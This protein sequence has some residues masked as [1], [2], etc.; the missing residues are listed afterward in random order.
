[1]TRPALTR[2]CLVVVF[3]A[4]MAWVEAASVYYLRAMVDRIEPY[5]VNP[6]P[7]HGVLGPVEVV[8]EAAT[9]VMLLMVGMLTARTWPRR[10]GYTAIA[11]GVWDILYYGFLKIICGW[12]TSIFDWDILFLLPLPWWGPVIAPVSIALL[13]VAWGTLATQFTDGPSGPRTAR[14]RRP[15]LGLG[16]VGIALALAVFMVDSLRTVNQGRDV[17]EMLPGPFNWPAFCV[18][19]ACMA[20]PVAQAGWRILNRTVDTGVNSEYIRQRRNYSRLAPEP[21]A[22]TEEH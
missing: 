16:G 14:G 22:E 1:M 15:L 6:L 19:L 4:G 21:H 8:R 12:P 7:I 17:R 11:F 20:M 2:W 3:A 9:L 10:L 5:Q 13:M 18:A